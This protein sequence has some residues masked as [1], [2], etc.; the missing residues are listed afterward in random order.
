MIEN[1]FA[2]PGRTGIVEFDCCQQRGIGWQHKKSAHARKRCHG[3]YRTYSQ[4]QG[5]GHEG[6]G[7]GRLGIEEHGGEEEDNSKHPWLGGQQI[8][9]QDIDFLEVR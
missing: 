4:R 1:V 6:L 8:S 2:D 3:R 7:G 9:S 5:N